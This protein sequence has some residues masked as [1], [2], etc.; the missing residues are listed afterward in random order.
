MTLCDTL[1]IVDNRVGPSFV[2][3]DVIGPIWKDLLKSRQLPD[4]C[5][6]KHN[7][8]IVIGNVNLPICRGQLLENIDFIGR[9][10]LAV[11]LIL[12]GHFSDCFGEAIWPKQRLV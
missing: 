4:I 5:Y 12:G 2:R 8:L 3:S 1:Y 9:G 7:P 11:P 10:K 6:A